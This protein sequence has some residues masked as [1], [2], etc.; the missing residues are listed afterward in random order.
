MRMSEKS[1]M[2]RGIPDRLAGGPSR[3][4]SMFRACLATVSLGSAACNIPTFT[5]Q[6]E[7][8]FESYGAPVVIAAC[9]SEGRVTG[10]RAEPRILRNETGW[11]QVLSPR[12]FQTARR[13][14][15]ELAYS[16]MYDAFFEPGIYRCVA[17]E[18]ALFSSRDKYDSGTGWPSF[19][20]LIAESNAIVSWDSGWG[21]RRRAVK[22]AKCGSHLGHVF[23]DGPPPTG[24]RYCLNSASLTFSPAGG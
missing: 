4:S 17:C 14:A 23:G 18:T 11:T 2:L 21:L 13:G 22:C 10:S 15:T 9:D 12:S 20:R 19:R 8:L 1:V 24:R 6:V 7:P 16:G 3:W 5:L